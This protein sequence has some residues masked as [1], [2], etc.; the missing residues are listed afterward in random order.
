MYLRTISR[1]AVKELSWVKERPSISDKASR[2][3]KQRK[4]D[5]S[6]STFLPL[7]AELPDVVHGIGYGS[8]VFPQ[9]GH[10]KKVM[11]DLILVVEDSK[12]WHEEVRRGWARLG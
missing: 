5:P 12:A 6:A 7:L 9:K 4:S 10:T 1:R 8:G 3:L 2:L 11:V